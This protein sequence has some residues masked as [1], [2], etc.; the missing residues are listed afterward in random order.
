MT[1][2]VR[3][4][5]DLN[6]VSLKLLGQFDTKDLARFALPSTVAFGY[7][8]TTPN[9]SATAYTF[10]A[11]SVIL[12]GVWAMWRPF[13]RPLDQ[14]LYQGLRWTAQ[15]SKVGSPEV[16][17]GSIVSDSS[18][19]ML[20]EVEPVNL[21]L[22]SG[23]EKAALHKQYQELLKSVDYPIQV[24]ST[25]HRFE[26]ES[27]FEDLVCKDEIQRDYRNYC[28]GLVE[29]GQSKVRHYVEVKAGDK[30]ELENRVEEVLEQ[31]N[32]GA[33]S[34]HQVTEPSRKTWSEPELNH[35][36]VTQSDAGK[37]QYS[38]TLYISEFPRDVGSFR[39]AKGG[40]QG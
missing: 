39:A 26:F 36:H 35:D 15:R 10:L 34:A 37:R 38:K 11:L 32:S 7:V 3:M 5:A 23:K 16:E 29:K 31:L 25:Q 21:E 19:S 27:Y 30:A 4:P 22:K 13:G 40:E 1:E 8:Y 12:G 20:I 17:S 9:P 6:K 24:Y 28:E 2:K 33:L 14:N 18:V